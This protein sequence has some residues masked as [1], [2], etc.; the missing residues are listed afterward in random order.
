MRQD[1]LKGLSVLLAMAIVACDGYQ[2]EGMNGEQA[3]A[4]SNQM[5]LPEAYSFYVKTYTG[6]SPPMLNVAQ[7]F[8]RFGAP[9]IAYIADKALNTQ[10]AE[11]FEADMMAFLILEYNCPIRLRKQLFDK[12]RKLRVNTALVNDGCKEA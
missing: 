3:L 12:A 2:Y 9:G 11:E 7:T 8:Q 5:D 1:I 4:T 6:T 10:D